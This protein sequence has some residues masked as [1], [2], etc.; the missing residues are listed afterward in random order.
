LKTPLSAWQLTRL[1]ILLCL[2][3]A[4]APAGAQ[5]AARDTLGPGDTVRITVFRYPDLTTEARISDKGTIVFPMIGEVKLSGLTADAA[6][7]RIASRLKDGKFLLNPQ[8]GVSPLQLRSRQASVL[9]DVAKPGRYAL[10]DTSTKLTDLLA[11]AGG[12]GPLAS[13]TVTIM[14]NRDGKTLKSEVNLPSVMRGL[15]VEKN[16]D[17]QNG[18]TVFVPR[19]PVFYIYGEVQK[20]GVYKLERGMTLMQAISVGGGITLRG[21]DRRLEVRR[22]TGDGQLREY[23]AKLSDT[24]QPDDV[25]YVKESFF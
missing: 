23:S 2:S 6:S 8:V 20:G 18:D 9:G 10:E 24:V 17:I 4:A 15:Q 25:I 22:R 12:L 21:S 14:S 19:A 11:M 13:D 5:S 3:F 7:A 1:F 16:I